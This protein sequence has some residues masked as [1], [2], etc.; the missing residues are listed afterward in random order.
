MR[1]LLHCCCAE[2][3]FK[4]IESLKGNKKISEVELFFSNSNIHPRTEYLARLEAAKFIANK[5]NLKLN[6]EDWSPKDWFRNVI[7][8]K[9]TQLKDTSRCEK[10]WNYRL[11]RSFEYATSKNFSLFSTTLL[12]SH[13]Q[14]E[15]QIN[16]IGRDLSQNLQENNKK[17]VEFLK[18]PKFEDQITTTGFYKQNYCGCIY[19]LKDRFEEKFKLSTNFN[20]KYK[21]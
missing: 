10:C 5:F 17:T 13:Y 1:L 18:L 19:S 20:F 11:T 2:C 14:N 15:D 12:T 7:N 16:K 3:T 6:I 9:D 21:V 4:A 8:K